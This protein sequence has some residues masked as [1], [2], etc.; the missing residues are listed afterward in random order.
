[1]TIRFFVS[2]AFEN[3]NVN[4]TRAIWIEYSGPCAFLL[5]AARETESFVSLRKNL[6]AKQAWAG[7]YHDGLPDPAFG[8]PF[9]RMN[10][11]RERFGDGFG[12]FNSHEKWALCFL[13]VNGHC[14]LF[15]AADENG[16]GLE[17]GNFDGVGADKV[18]PICPAGRRRCRVE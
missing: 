1:M 10:C 13:E 14:L 4:G 17:G 3:D 12:E 18:H 2:W 7:A 8:L 15:F 6:V 16:N 11:I 5:F 9:V